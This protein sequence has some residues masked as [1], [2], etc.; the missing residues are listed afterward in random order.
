MKYQKNS[1]TL[2]CGRKDTEKFDVINSV[3][4]YYAYCSAK[5]QWFTANFTACTLPEITTKKKNVT[6][7]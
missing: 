7:M 5:H 4:P 3:V 6:V 2:E 1:Q